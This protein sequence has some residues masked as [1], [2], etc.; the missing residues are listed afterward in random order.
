MVLSCLVDPLVP[1]LVGGTSGRGRKT[2][3]S[4]SRLMSTALVATAL[5]AV[6]S[7]AGHSSG[8]AKA[9]GGKA[10]PTIGRTAHRPPSVRAT[11]CLPSTEVAALR[12][13]QQVR[14][15]RP[16]SAPDF[17]WDAIRAH[18]L[19]HGRNIARD[20]GPGLGAGRRIDRLDCAQSILLHFASG[21]PPAG[22]PDAHV[23]S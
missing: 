17:E 9:F 5:A 23:Q 4:G 1:P 6:V 10:Q 8:Q 13:D 20:G 12:D 22:A 11:G 16:G 2:R 19:R 7:L 21:R 15:S 18:R 14:P 3:L